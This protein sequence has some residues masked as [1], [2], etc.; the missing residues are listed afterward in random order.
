MSLER[1]LSHTLPQDRTKRGVPRLPATRGYL[2]VA[3]V[4]EMQACWA[5][6]PAR[7]VGARPDCTQLVLGTGH[8]NGAKGWR[9]TEGAAALE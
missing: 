7:R 8:L 5:G 3:G 4:R 9:R 6:S 2:H 1:L